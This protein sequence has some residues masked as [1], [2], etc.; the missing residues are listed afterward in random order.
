VR[1]VLPIVAGRR[2]GSIEFVIR[3]LH[4]GAG[5]SDKQ[6]GS[7]TPLSQAILARSNL[8]VQTI[9]TVFRSLLAARAVTALTP[10]G[11]VG[12][13]G[14]VL[15]PHGPVGAAERLILLNATGIMLVVVVPVIVLTLGFVWWFRSTNSRATYS[16]NWSYSGRIEFVVWSIPAMVVILL[17]A[18]SWTG[19]H[20]LDPGAKLSSDVRPLSIEVVSVDWKWLFIYPGPRLATVNTLV[21]P[22]GT[23][24]QFTLTSAS[25]MNAF[26]VPQL[27]SQIYTMPGMATRLNLLAELPGD[28]PGLSS[29]FSGDGFSD[30]HFL[31]HA[32]S[33]S[34]FAR[35]VARNQAS[36][37]TLNA[38]AYSKLAIPSSD[39][40][41]QAY[42]NV[43]PALFATIVSATAHPFKSNQED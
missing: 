40:P 42:R 8:E 34:D 12:C 30:M 33:A 36:G 32:V 2:C 7:G 28:Y 15:D 27:G 39:A 4:S 19:S 17:A 31:V 22:A 25:V 10:I 14:G 23:P 6:F 20:L 16:P 9:P 1:S 38:E 3:Q 43:D 26:F 24:L 21:V 29:H 41:P 18:V 37:P 35:W 11:L 13:S 5:Q